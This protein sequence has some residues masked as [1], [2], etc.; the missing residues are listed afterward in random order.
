MKQTEYTAVLDA[1]R[2]AKVWIDYHHMQFEKT[3][4]TGDVIIRKVMSA[5]KI[6]EAN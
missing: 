3:G 6:M 2:D 1:L 4:G 5:I